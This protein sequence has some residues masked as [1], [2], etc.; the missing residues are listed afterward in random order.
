MTDATVH[1]AVQ[2]GFFDAFSTKRFL[3]SPSLHSTQLIPSLVRLELI[4]HS[5]HLVFTHSLSLSSR[6]LCNSA[7]VLKLYI[8]KKN[9]NAWIAGQGVPNAALRNLRILWILVS[10]GKSNTLQYCLNTVDFTHSS[11][12]SVTRFDPLTAET[13][14]E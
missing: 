3:S 6:D 13:T 11:I 4:D 5:A 14:S 12:R 9:P 1:S 2:K 7:Q 8:L 10:R